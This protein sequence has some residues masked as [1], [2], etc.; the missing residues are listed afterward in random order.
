ML[1][2]LMII[3]DTSAFAEVLQTHNCGNTVCAREIPDI[4]RGRRR[5]VRFAS[6]RG[7]WRMALAAIA[8]LTAASTLTA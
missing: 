8:A 4:R 6:M 3:T 2:T 5:V 1:R 7:Q